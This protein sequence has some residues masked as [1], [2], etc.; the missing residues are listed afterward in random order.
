MKKIF[1][2]LIV[3][4]S[5]GL[6]YASDYDPFNGSF[7]MYNP[8]VEM[9]ILDKIQS[10]TDPDTGKVMIGGLALKFDFLDNALE[11]VDGL[12]VAAVHFVDSEDKYILD[13]HVDGN[14]VVKIMLASKNGKVINKELYPAKNE[15]SS[16][17]KKESK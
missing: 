3:L 8:T 6:L 11:E 17:E 9:V 13:Y 7:S 14:N 12:S 2:I 5:S 4:F 10:Q 16:G 15:T 1:L